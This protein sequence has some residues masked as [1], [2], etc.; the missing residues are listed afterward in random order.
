MDALKDK[1]AI[2]TGAGHPKGIGYAT[3]LKL[4]ENG[5]S[6]VVLDLPNTDGIDLAVDEIQAKNVKSLG[7]GCDVSDRG[8]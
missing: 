5:A 4:A 7:L 1:V 6:V 8:W 2:V 3:A